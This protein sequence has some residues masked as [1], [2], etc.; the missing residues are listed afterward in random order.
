MFENKLQSFTKL[1]GRM[2]MYADIRNVC[3][4]HQR[5]EDG[6]SEVHELCLT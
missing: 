3:A 5:L 1:W 4:I 2:E 6:I